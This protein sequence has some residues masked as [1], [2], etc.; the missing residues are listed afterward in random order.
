MAEKIYA[1]DLNSEE[2]TEWLLKELN[3][4]KFRADQICQW[5]WQKRVFNAEQMTNLSMQL[6]EELSQRVDFS[7]PSMLK[8]QRS[9][10]D[11]T[12]KYLWQ[13]RDGNSV[14][15][16]LLRQDDRLTACVSTQV[17]CPLQC[18]FCA[19]GISGY[20]RNLTAGEIAGQFLAMEAAIGRDINNIVYMGMGEPFLN[21][22]NVLKSVR[23]LNSPKMRNL[24]IRHMTISTS[25]VV[26]G[27]LELAQSGL[28]VRLA[29]S[30][31]AANDELRDMLM[32]VNRTFPLDELRGAMQ[33]YQRKTNDRITIEYMLLGGVNDSAEHARELVRFLKGIHVFINLIPFNDVDARYQRPGPATV[34]RFRTILETAGFES[35]IRQEQGSDID[36][37]CG[38]LR[39]KSSA[40]EG[41][42]A[43]DSSPRAGKTDAVRADAR[44]SE[45]RTKKNR[46]AG[47]EGAPQGR[48]AKGTNQ[49][50]V[51]DTDERR[52][53]MARKKSTPIFDSQAKEDG[54]G[55]KP[56]R[57]GR[58]FPKRGDGS[59]RT[60]GD[61]S[62]GSLRGDTKKATTRQRPDS[63]AAARTEQQRGK[64]TALPKGE[65]PRKKAVRARHK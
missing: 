27:I 7:P 4:P 60:E 47:K 55:G 36:A 63:S 8:E 25:G 29:V 3:Q 1:L 45:P 11:G 21:T 46:P 59:S 41:S 32:P 38:Q 54:H 40:G 49:R 20:V 35:E 30:L 62:K 42:S 58:K 52:R 37:A 22:E 5:V 9:K 23:M 16:V 65:R 12:R 56:E 26:P 53:G 61:R 34:L 43:E 48:A 2:W 13:L 10:I 15:S 64:K 17:G 28:G 57:A 51:K 33:E 6:R 18:A 50:G 24:G 14:E 19:T 31:H 44:E 39:R